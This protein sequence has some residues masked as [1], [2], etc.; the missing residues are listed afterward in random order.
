MN[1]VQK[2]LVIF[3]SLT[4]VVSS[5]M[6]A[7]SVAQDH[8]HKTPH[9]GIVQEADGMHAEFLLDKNGQPKLYLY[10]KAMKPL[11]RD[12]Q[13]MLT[14]KAHDGTEHKRDLK[15]SKD[16]KEGP[17][18]IGEPIKGLTDWDTAVVSVKMK[19]GWKHIRFSHHSDG[20]GH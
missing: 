8:G 2:Y 16:A 10:D 7:D 19:D 6:F 4:V 3:F 13:A 14:V 12:L 18:F 1:R 5:P 11:E 9:G 17:L 20:H 15:F